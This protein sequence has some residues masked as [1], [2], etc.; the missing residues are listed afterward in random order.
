MINISC[1]QAG[2]VSLMPCQA[3]HARC[4]MF[5]SAQGCSIQLVAPRASADVGS[6]C[7][8]RFGLSGAGKVAT[9]VVPIY[10]SS[11]NLFDTI[12]VELAAMMG[13]PA[14]TEHSVRG[15]ERPG[16]RWPP[17]QVGEPSTGTVTGPQAEHATDQVAAINVSDCLFSWRSKSFDLTA[18]LQ[19]HV[20]T[21]PRYLR[22]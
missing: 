2:K 9:V 16:E 3:A 18:C 17:R 6:R 4:I 5:V 15:A 13:A 22:L 8:I 20:T 19:G 12:M 10:K 7:C 14:L 11:A 1:L 21:L